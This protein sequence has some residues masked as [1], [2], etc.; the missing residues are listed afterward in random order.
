MIWVKLGDHH[1]N[2][3]EIQYVREVQVEDMPKSI[4]VVLRGQPIHNSHLIGTNL[5]G[6]QWKHFLQM[7]KVCNL[8]EVYTVVMKEEKDERD[9]V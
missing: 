6:E 5:T 2:M 7:Q 9:K 1:Y 8:K 4:V 3:E